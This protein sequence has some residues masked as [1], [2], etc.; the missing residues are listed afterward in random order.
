MRGKNFVLIVVMIFVFMLSQVFNAS[1]ISQDSNLEPITDVKSVAAGYG[2]MVFVKNDGTVW[3]CGRN[4]LGELGIGDT[5]SINAAE[6]VFGL[7]DVID[8]AAGED[9]SLVLHKDGTVWA[10]G[11]NYFG[12]I[13][14]GSLGDVLRNIYIQTPTKVLN[15][16][17]VTDI[18]AGSYHS[19]AL[20]NDGTVWMWGGFAEINNSE[21]PEAK[22]IPTK[23][24]GLTDVVA[25]A[26]GYHHI[27]ALKS[28][29]SV[30][31]MGNNHIGQLGIGS[32][33]DKW[34]PV[35]VEGLNDIVG[36]F[37]GE[38]NTFAIKS[39]GTVWACGANFYGEF[40][41][42]S[43]K[44]VNIP[45]KIEGLDD[46]ICVAACWESISIAKSDGTIWS[47]G[48]NYSGQLGNNITEETYIPV[49]VKGITDI[50]S[51]SAGSRFKM[52]INSKGD[53]FTWGD[54][55]DGQ[56]SL[57]EDIREEF[58]PKQAL[59]N[60]SYDISDTS[61]RNIFVNG[62]DIEM[63]SPEILH[64]K[65]NFSGCPDVI[66]SINVVPSNPDSKTKVIQ[67]PNMP[68]TAFIEVVAEDGMATETYSVEFVLESETPIPM[69][70]TQVD[71]SI[72][73]RRDNAISVVGCVTNAVEE[74]IYIKVYNSIDELI[75]DGR[76]L[77]G[78]DG[79]YYYFSKRLK[80]SDENGDIYSIY[81]TTKGIEDTVK[82]TYSYHLDT[83]IPNPTATPTTTPTATPTPVND[84]LNG[85]INGNGNV[86]ALDFALFRLYLLGK[87]QTFTYPYGL[88]AADVNHDDM[89]NSIDFAMLRAYLLGMI[90]IK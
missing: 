20:K 88:Q 13:G 68:G 17:S 54:N 32:F 38:D 37:A 86:D 77:M 51:V 40:G 39:D 29:G 19:I 56:L 73:S 18:A 62:R 72:A 90:D 27:V 12:Q 28:D 64:Y 16:D 69:P 63:F 89:V 21:P 33:E 70:A 61:L 83:C 46:V 75:F 53:L 43:S 79:D 57:G 55:C 84:I 3:A 10:W 31:A 24:E 74:Y 71:A 76:D 23:V 25:I 49:E 41:T 14:D 1:A 60:N 80:V 5:N 65:V 8:V 45:V 52:A 6:R 85:D 30:W 2:H 11:N 81:L 34:E 58:F 15:L 9:F 35:K 78:R 67:A 59:A 47:L 36:I 44:E 82:L 66:P 42:V 87:I 50:V 7:S 26:S 22:G 48:D 4:S